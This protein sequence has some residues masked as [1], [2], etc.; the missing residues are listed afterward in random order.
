[1]GDDVNQNGPSSPLSRALDTSKL[2]PVPGKRGVCSTKRRGSGCRATSWWATASSGRRPTPSRTS[3]FRAG[4]W[5]SP[6]RRPH[7]VAGERFFAQFEGRGQDPAEA[8][9]ETASFG[10]VERVI[11]TAEEVDAGF[12]LGVGG[13]KAID[14]AK[15]A[16]DDLD[17]GFVSVPTAASHDGIVSG[18]GS[19]PEG[20]TR[21][22]V[23]SELPLAVV[24]DT[25][26][27]PTRPGS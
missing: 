14:I 20:D 15:M 6:A 4:R 21:H 13:G 2:S 24:A 9:V 7:E 19:V 23:A 3:T 26:S 16:A 17:L 1:V 27:S 8:I 11:E 18:R 25:G 5:W 10:A 22:S 12:L